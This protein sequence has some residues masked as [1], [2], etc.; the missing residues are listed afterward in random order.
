[1]Q[2]TAK[3]DEERAA[4]LKRLQ[5]LTQLSAEEILSR[6]IDLVEQQQVELCRERSD[7]ILNS[8]FVGCLKDAPEDLATNHR[9][10]FAEAMQE[11][12]DA[13]QEQFDAG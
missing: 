3:L 10:Y 5:S 13:M 6:G 4:K 12:Y 11:K 1:M 7:A 9:Q 2:V 8:G